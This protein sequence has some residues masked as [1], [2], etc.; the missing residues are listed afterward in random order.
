MKR[1]FPAFFTFA[2][3]FFL[4][5]QPATLAAETKFYRTQVE[6]NGTATIAGFQEI[7][8]YC[9]YAVK[10][11]YEYHDE[12][13]SSGHV[14]YTNNRGLA[15]AVLQSGSISSIQNGSMSPSSYNKMSFPLSFEQFDDLLAS[16]LFYN[17]SPEQSEFDP[18]NIRSPRLEVDVYHN[19]YEHKTYVYARLQF[20]TIGTHKYETVTYSYYS[21]SDSQG[22]IIS[23]LKEDC[24]DP[25]AVG[26][27][28]ITAAASYGGYTAERMIDGDSN[29]YFLGPYGQTSN[30][31]EF[32][33][34]TPSVLKQ[35][36][37]DWFSSFYACKHVSLSVV[38][39]FNTHE[40]IAEYNGGQSS[41]TSA[42][43]TLK[44]D[45]NAPSYVSSQY[46]LN[47]SDCAYYAGVIREMTLEVGSGW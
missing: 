5:S 47:I 36:T 14:N 1:T 9:D 11:R 21:Y 4:T 10:I 16:G 41:S 28:S 27:Q 39:D 24:P 2:L 32:Y 31:F 46:V 8:D 30:S 42:S 25:A 26:V 20:E 40:L 6:S 19:D 33:L 44:V 45:E 38:T 7:K 37:L 29:T 17:Q 12:T 18:L 35:L 15:E 22:F 34:E 23:A 13:D 43:L 3:A